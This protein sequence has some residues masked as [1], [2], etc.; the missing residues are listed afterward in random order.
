[1]QS[2]PP[3]PASAAVAGDLD[4]VFPDSWPLFQRTENRG[5]CRFAKEA[6]SVYLE[7]SRLNV[8]G[9]SRPEEYQ[10]ARPSAY[11]LGSLFMEGV[12]H[13]GGAMSVVLFFD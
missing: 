9:E 3:V 10:Y 8:K 11:S 7:Q 4:Q 13:C 2:L 5:S 1:M 12:G 6:R